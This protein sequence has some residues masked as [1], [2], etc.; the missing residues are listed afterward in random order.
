MKGKK[1]VLSIAVLALLL[2]GLI[3]GAL[4]HKEYCTVCFVKSLNPEVIRHFIEGFGSWAIVVYVLLYTVNTL[5]LIP[6][7]AFMSLLHIISYDPRIMR[8]KVL[9]FKCWD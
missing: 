3:F 8:T 2:G 9:S 1:L 7:I 6:P 4:S 5:T